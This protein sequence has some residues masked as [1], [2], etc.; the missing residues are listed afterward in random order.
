MLSI[1]WNKDLLSAFGNII[2]N[3]C[4]TQQALHNEQSKNAFTLWKHIENKNI[5][6]MLYILVN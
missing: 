2:V 6:T 4:C 5:D 3:D 1:V